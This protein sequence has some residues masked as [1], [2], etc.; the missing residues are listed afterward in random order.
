MTS[1]PRRPVPVDDGRLHELERGLA[2]Q[3]SRSRRAW[4]R[5]VAADEASDSTASTMAHQDWSDAMDG[6]LT[7]VEAISTAP[8]RD[9][10]G[11]LIQFEATWWWIKEDDNV[12]DGST[13]RWLGRFRRSLRTLTKEG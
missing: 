2:Q 11:L 8:V 10:R 12:L 1:R 5:Y 7:I 4:L 6:A 3:R 9:L 13:R